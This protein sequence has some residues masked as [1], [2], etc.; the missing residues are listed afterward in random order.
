[1]THKRFHGRLSDKGTFRKSM[2]NNFHMLPSA[3]EGI[4]ESSIGSAG[5]LAARQRQ[6]HNMQTFDDELSGE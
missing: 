1:M 3:N 5:S 4:E 6:F 2:T